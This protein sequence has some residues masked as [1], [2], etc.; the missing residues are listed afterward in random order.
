MIHPS[1]RLGYIN[2]EKGKGV[3]ATRFI[4]KGTVTYV[5]DSLE[6]EITADD[7]RLSDPLYKDIIETYSYIDRDGTK[8]L[9]WDHAKYVNHCCQCNTMSTGYGFEI[10]VRDIEAEEEMTDEYGMFNFNNTL[11]LKCD[12]SPCRD[13]VTG[14]DVDKYYTK[15]DE[16]VKDALVKFNNVEQPLEK[17]IK[18]ETVRSLNEYLQSGNNYQSVLNLKYPK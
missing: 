2:N 1:T 5:K 8:V 11:E 13:V 15:W 4:P 17:F 18:P 10:A 7:P 12:K 6:I 9:S 14:R 3:I 16:V